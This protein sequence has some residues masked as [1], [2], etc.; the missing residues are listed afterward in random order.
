MIV[1]T[2]PSGNVGAELTEQLA[3]GRPPHT[4]DDYLTDNARRWADRAWT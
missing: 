2:G 4:L 3:V 1:V